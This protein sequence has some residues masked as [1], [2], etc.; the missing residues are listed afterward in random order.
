MPKTRPGFWAKKLR[1][2]VLRDEAT[3]CALQELG[4]HVITVWECELEQIEQ[5]ERRLKRA[6]RRKVN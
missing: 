4:W 1:G 2:N 3:A 6:F 5:L